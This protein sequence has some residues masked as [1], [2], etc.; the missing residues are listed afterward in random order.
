MKLQKLKNQNIE[1]KNYK[2]KIWRAKG[3]KPRRLRINTNEGNKSKSKE[4]IDFL[5]AWFLESR[6]EWSQPFLD[7]LQKDG[8]LSSP[9]KLKKQSKK[10][11]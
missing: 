2:I 7:S 10:E 6:P 9:L 1:S 11:W 4:I 3:N 8:G 5:A